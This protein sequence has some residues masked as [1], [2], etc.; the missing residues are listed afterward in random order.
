MSICH[1]DEYWKFCHHYVE[2]EILKTVEKKKRHIFYVKHLKGYGKKSEKA[3]PDFE[4]YQKK[5]HVKH[6]WNTTQNPSAFCVCHVSF[7]AFNDEK[8]LAQNTPTA[9]K[10]SSLRELNDTRKGPIILRCAW[11]PL[12]IY[13][14]QDWKVILW[15]PCASPKHSK[16]I[17]I[18]FEFRAL[19]FHK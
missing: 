13:K 4:V 18:Q 1:L 8:T 6:V 2:V 11:V 15:A 5:R 9:H 17:L 14:K 7:E 16:S 19:L 3:K 10:F 12:F